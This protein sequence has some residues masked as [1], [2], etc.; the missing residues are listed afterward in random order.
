MS[1]GV[2]LP[3]DNHRQ[4]TV[5]AESACRPICCSLG[6]GYA[7]TRA[8]QAPHARREEASRSR[9]I[10]LQHR[11]RAT[12][13]AEK[14]LCVSEEA[15]VHQTSSAPLKLPMLLRLPC[16]LIRIRFGCYQGGPIFRR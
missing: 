2:D 12:V 1:F 16:C 14:G 13:R 6:A 5:R 10:M 3:V 8:A 9:R 4:D 11:P 7:A 15:L